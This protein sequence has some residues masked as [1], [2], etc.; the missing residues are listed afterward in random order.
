M[1]P[2]LRL[3][4]DRRARSRPRCDPCELR[5]PRCSSRSPRRTSSVAWLLRA[6]A[7]DAAQRD[8]GVRLDLRR[9]GQRFE[10]SARERAER[11]R[12][13]AVHLRQHRQPQGRG[14]HARQPAREHPRDGHARRAS[15]SAR[16]VREL[17]AA[18]PRHG[19]DR[20]VAWHAVPRRTARADV[21]AELPGAARTLA[22]G[23][24]PP[25]RHDLG[26]A[27]LRLRA[28]PR[29]SPD[30]EL[31]GLDLCA[32]WRLAFN[33]AEPVQRGNARGLRRRFA[34]LWL[35]REALCRR[36]TGWPSAR[37]G[38]AFP[39]LGPRADAS[40]ASSA[41]R[42]VDAT[43]RGAGAA[44][45]GHRRCE[46]V[47]LR[48]AAAGSRDPHRRRRGP[49]A[50]ASAPR[51]A[52]QFRGPSATARLLPQ[53][54]GDR[55]SCSHGDWLDTGDVGYIADGELYRHRAASRT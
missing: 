22:A 54:R 13:A 44:D 8:H 14:A 31:D 39:P 28:V 37:S 29:Q 51:G 42:L 23:D 7:P 19:P 48:A 38:L 30:E 20:R 50:A 47:S 53:S 18:L 21:A 33:G 35:R 52:L 6:Q 2:P 16:R 43:A 9:A 46:V 26:G 45:D 15:T 25:S 40:T 11:H 5:V 32:R 24:P 3:V 27:E 55:A 1:Y 17:A 4:A 34:P 12:I 36:C 10:G 41:R 49:R